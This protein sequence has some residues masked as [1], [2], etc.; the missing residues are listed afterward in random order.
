MRRFLV[1]QR[2]HRGMDPFSFMDNAMRAMFQ[3]VADPLTDD[4][5]KSLI[6]NM[7]VYRKDGIF[8]LLVDLPGIDREDIDLKVYR[9]RVEIR[10][11]RKSCCEFEDGD[12]A[13]NERFFGS[14]SRTV[15]LPA[16][17]DCDSVQASYSDGVLKVEIKELKSGGEGKTIVIGNGK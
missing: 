14:I 10:A 5:G 17:V 4:G 8:T 7:D 1:P 6:P 15:T 13:H 11:Q 16:E 3:D 2:T 12:C 9:D